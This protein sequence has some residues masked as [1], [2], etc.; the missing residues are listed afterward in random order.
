MKIIL[1]SSIP[2]IV[3]I[4]GV[5]FSSC[6]SNSSN[7]TNQDS[8]KTTSEKHSGEHTF[9]CPMHAEVT[10][11]E[12]DSCPKCGMKLVHNDN[13]GNSSFYLMKFTSFPATIAANQKA[14]LSFRPRLKNNDKEPVALDAVHEKKVHLIVV[15]DD[16][17]YF[18]HIHPELNADGLYKVD[19]SF[20][21][22]GKYILFADYKPSGGNKTVDKINIDVSGASTPEK[23][24]STNKLKGSSGKYSF[25]LQPTG[26]RFVTGVLI[27]ING[28]VKKDGKNYDAKMLENFLGAKAHIVF[29]SLNDNEYIHLQP[30]VSGGNF[31][32]HTNFEKPGIYRGWVQF[33]AEATIH[34]VDFTIN[35]AEGTEQ[36]RETLNKAHSDFH[37]GTGSK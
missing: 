28:I 32:I 20:P 37:T 25:T 33:K 8:T 27:H 29:I 23:F 19:Y 31:D 3:L 5:T 2:I 13:A 11:K 14:G 10:G 21:S 22:G 35:V 1:K 36:D 18:D 24:H 16:L 34:T 17:S 12:G 30:A 4:I 15:N 6:S 26:G 9:A 7:T